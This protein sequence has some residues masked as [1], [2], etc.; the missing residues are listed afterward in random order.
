MALT[1][2]QIG[3]SGKET[4]TVVSISANGNTFTCNNGKMYM[5]ATATWMTEGKAVEVK[6]VKVKRAKR[7]EACPVDF[8]SDENAKGLDLD[9]IN[10]RSKM[11]QR[12]SS[13][14]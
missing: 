7:F 12:G 6:E 4:L 9:E 3:T 5:T 10:L 14:R 11:N 2:G 1:I 13:M 8:Y